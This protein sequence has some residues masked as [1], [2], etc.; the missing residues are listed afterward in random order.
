VATK[1]KAAKKAPD[2]LHAHEVKN[3][4]QRLVENIR[5]YPVL[6]GAGVL[7]VV[8]CLVAGLAYR[9]NTANRTVD[10]TTQFARAV[11]TEDPALRTTQLEQLSQGGPLAADAVYLAGEA[12]YQAKDY[13]K[14]KAFFQQLRT[15]FPQ[16]KFAPDA[17]EGLGFI[18]E[19]EG[20]PDGA[21]AAYNEVIEKWPGSVARRRQELNIARVQEQKGN[22]KE[23]VDAY[24]FH[25]ENY[26]ESNFMPEVD[27]ALDRLKQTHPELFPAE[28]AASVPAAETPVAAPEAETPAAAPEAAVAPSAEAPAVAP[29]AAAAPSAEAPAPAPQA[30]A[31]AAE[32][33]EATPEP[34]EA[35]A[36]Q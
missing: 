34:A 29:E 16:S 24:K 36:Q 18:S 20:D 7:F 9:M 12:A 30:P 5:D 26:P 31:P 28:A 13:A 11:T 33:P 25:S 35:P 14:A 2:I 21:L 3:D 15:D 10:A 17:V 19:N 8:V 23:A 32:T 1:A 27:K 4:W 22:L 6:W